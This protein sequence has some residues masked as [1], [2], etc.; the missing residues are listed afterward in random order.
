[1]RCD[2]AFRGVIVK[3]MGLCMRFGTKF[4]IILCDLRL[5][6][7]KELSQGHQGFRSTRSVPQGEQRLRRKSS[8][9]QRDQYA[10]ARNK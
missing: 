1:M 6:I 7:P 10:V 8:A 9:R 2:L 3:A 4:N 5:S